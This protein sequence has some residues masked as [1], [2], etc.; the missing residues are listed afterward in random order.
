M[1]E[2]KAL[3]KMMADYHLWAYQQLFFSLKKVPDSLYFSEA[4]KL[5]FG[6][7]H[8]TLNHLC[9][10]D[11]LWYGRFIQQPLAVTGLNQE[12]YKNRDELQ[13]AIT[14]GA[15]QWV[16]YVDA[17]LPEQLRAPLEYKNTK[18]VAN[19]FLPATTLLHVFNHGTHHRGQMTAAL[20]ALGFEFEPLDLF[21]S[22]VY[23]EIKSLG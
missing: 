6:S 1:S 19:T 12:L 17:A 15:E 14:K 16:N 4:P 11:Q 23:Q 21:Y 9:L 13:S 22:P 2:T 5:F 8:G 7:I 3:I 20:T 10:I 18:G